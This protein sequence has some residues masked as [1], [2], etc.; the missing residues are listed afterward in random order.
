[1]PL[2]FFIGR[3]GRLDGP[4]TTATFSA[5]AENRYPTPGRRRLP[6][7][8]VTT[9]SGLSI[10]REPTFKFAKRRSGA[11]MQLGARPLRLI[12]GCYVPRPILSVTG[13][14]DERTESF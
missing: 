7:H 8:R 13:S 6:S 12:E 3:R 10:A 11:V 14:N 9:S 1:M 5:G 4:R 2:A